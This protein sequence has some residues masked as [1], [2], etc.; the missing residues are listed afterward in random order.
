MSSLRGKIISGFSVI[1]LLLVLMSGYSLYNV[2]QINNDVE[3]IVQ[4]DLERVSLSDELAYNM[5]ERLALVR[6]YILL[7]KKE[8]KESYIELTEQSYVLEEELLAIHEDI[9]I[10]NLVEKSQL[11]D[12][13]ISG[14]IFPMFEANGRETAIISI[15][16]QVDPLAN[17]VVEGYHQLA[18]AGKEHIINQGKDMMSRGDTIVLFNIIAT[19]IGIVISLVVAL[20]T[21]KKI[22]APITAVVNV[23]ERVA[24]GDLTGKAIEVKSNDELGRLTAS[25][26]EMAINLRS[27]LTK[28]TETSSQVAAASEELTAS[29]HQT[30]VATNQIAATIK[31]VAQGAEV[32]VSGTKESARAMEEMTTG[33]QRIAESSSVVAESSLDATHE[34]QEGNK[35]L[36]RVIEQMNSISE[37]V[38][39]AT[40]IIG[41]LGERS[42]EIGSILGVI[43]TI[44]DQTNLL[45]LNAAIEAARAGEHGKGFA[46]VADE[47]RKLAEESRQSAA[48][49]SSVIHEIQAETSVAVKTMDN[50]TKEVE[51]G[52]NVVE[53][54]GYAFER[55]LGAIQNVSSQIQEV[56]ATAEQ[57]SASSEE[58]SASVDEMANVAVETAEHFQLVASGA[59]QQLSSMEE[60]KTS[61]NNLSE[62]A[63]ELQEEIKKFKL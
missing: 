45:A 20:I 10:I 46:V 15:Q 26:N 50:G 19:V 3:Q 33:I 17:E 39:E 1:L 55:I 36:Q 35:S 38:K 60:I 9:K 40:V 13:L 14:R 32:T 62:L 52:I 43:T 18:L 44:A 58:V 24:K 34:A 8:Y 51:A 63:Q 2:H 28:T 42:N 16:Y 47:V 31:D 22:V 11:W 59:E 7:G 61:A 57:M 25:T 6:G 12:R 56:S 37:A 29:S 30:T 21:A 23:V 5:A 27:L 4:E 48:K 54:T 49:I 53:E 41:R